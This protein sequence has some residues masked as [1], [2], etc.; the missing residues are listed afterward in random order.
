MAIAKYTSTATETD[1]GDLVID[2]VFTIPQAESRLDQII[3]GLVSGDKKARLAW[4]NEGEDLLKKAPAYWLECMITTACEI[5][6]G[7]Y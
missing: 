2:L 7:R 3:F 4:I 6:E 1:L 5:K